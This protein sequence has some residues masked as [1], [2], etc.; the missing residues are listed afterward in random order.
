VRRGHLTN[1]LKY[2]YFTTLLFA[3]GLET[4]AAAKI[5]AAIVANTD[6]GEEYIYPRL[7]DSVGQA[8]YNS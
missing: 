2:F 1:R 7:N 4:Q 3:A 8:A 6:S 5:S